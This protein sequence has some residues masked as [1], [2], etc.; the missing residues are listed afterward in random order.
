MPSSLPTSQHREGS[1]LAGGPEGKESGR[2][3]ELRAETKAEV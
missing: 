2:E 3:T 1:G